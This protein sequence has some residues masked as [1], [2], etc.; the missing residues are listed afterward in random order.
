MPD[1]AEEKARKNLE[2]GK[3]V[4]LGMILLEKIKDKF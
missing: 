1:T 2:E 4:G 3:G